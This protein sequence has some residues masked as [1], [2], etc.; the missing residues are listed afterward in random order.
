MSTQHVE[1]DLDDEE[2]VV[3]GVAYYCDFAIKATLSHT[4]ARVSGPPEDCYPEESEIDIEEMKLN[5]VRDEN[6]E[7]LILTP[8]L[9]KQLSDA[10]NIDRV[11]ELLWEEWETESDLAAAR[12]DYE[13][14]RE[15]D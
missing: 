12:A 2:I 8:P 7:A 10:L 11:H 6:G 13:Y 5:E 1:L 3:D 9:L 14:D 4:P 15:D